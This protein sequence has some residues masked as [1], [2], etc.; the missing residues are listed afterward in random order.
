MDVHTPEKR[1]Y[2]MSRIEGKNTKPEIMVRKWLWS[3]GYRYKLYNKVLPGKPDIVFPGRKKV[4]FIHGCF[5]H[6]HDCRYFKWP[7]TNIEFWKQKIGSTVD[8]DNKNYALLS[9]AGWCYLVIWECETKEKDPENL[10]RKI[11]AFLPS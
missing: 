2:N 4:I 8:R 11:E 10:L 5:W 7:E 6:R 3:K 1:S 9:D